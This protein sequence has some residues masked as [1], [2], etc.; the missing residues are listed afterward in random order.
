MKSILSALVACVL[1]LTCRAEENLVPLF[2]TK[3]DVREV[4][5]LYE[6]LSNKPVFVALDLQA[7][8]T[9]NTPKPI[10]LA[11]AI[12]LIRTTLLEHYGIELRTTD[13]GEILAAWSKDPK[14]PRG[15]EPPLTKAERDALSQWGE[16]GGGGAPR[17]R[18]RVIKP[19]ATR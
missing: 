9:V 6:R 3:C 16:D 17:N 2:L 10:P 19:D 12:E 11:D 7:S 8:V 15:T 1:P 14:Y 18:I 5:A 4:L 13:R